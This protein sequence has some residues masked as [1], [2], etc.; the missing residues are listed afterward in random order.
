[1]HQTLTI[2]KYFNINL[3]LAFWTRNTREVNQGMQSVC[4][5]TTV[6]SRRL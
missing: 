5:I 6:C 4:C 2:W 1:M 3:K